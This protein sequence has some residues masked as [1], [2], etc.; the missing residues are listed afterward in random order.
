M[1]RGRSLRLSQTLRLVFGKVN[2]SCK[3]AVER[4]WYLPSWIWTVGTL[5]SPFTSLS[6]CTAVCKMQAALPRGVS[7]G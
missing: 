1:T 2:V 3:D 5:A 6:L 7:R 4:G